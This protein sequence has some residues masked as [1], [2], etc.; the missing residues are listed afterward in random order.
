MLGYYSFSVTCY[1]T[2]LDIQRDYPSLL[3]TNCATIINVLNSLSYQ[4]LQ[5]DVAIFFNTTVR[6]FDAIDGLKKALF[7]LFV[8]LG[9]F[10]R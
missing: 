5:R 10:Q 3:S 7:A 6:F 2:N 4:H 8:D 1:P 9:G